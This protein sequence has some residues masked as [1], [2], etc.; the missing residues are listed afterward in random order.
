[1]SDVDGSG[2]SL[3]VDHATLHQVAND[4][5]SANT[6]V[7]KHLGTVRGAAEVLGGAWTG[8][9]ATAFTNLML[10]WDDDAKKLAAAMD[11]IANLLD[12]SANSHEFNDAE[13]MR[14]LRGMDGSVNS[15]LNPS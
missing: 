13:S 2:R 3:E 4:I 5:R 15:I 9:A 14:V 6:D 7:N 10:R 8:Q 12:K 11:D 1:M